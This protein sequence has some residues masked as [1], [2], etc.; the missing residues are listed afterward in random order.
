[1]SPP[2]PWRPMSGPPLLRPLLLCGLMRCLLCHSTFQIHHCAPLASL[3]S[4]CNI[5]LTSPTGSSSGIYCNRRSSYNIKTRSFHQYLSSQTSLSWCSVD[6]KSVSLCKLSESNPVDRP[7]SSEVSWKLLALLT[8]TE[9]LLSI[10]SLLLFLTVLNSPLASSD[11]K[12]LGEV[13]SA[14]GVAA[15]I[16]YCYMCIQREK[17]MKSHFRVN[18]LS[19]PGTPDLKILATYHSYH[20]T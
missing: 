12:I 7:P 18:L 17:Q 9:T 1:M 14:F 11:V 8:S 16:T 10:D 6:S 15:I 2:P 20:L 5:L 19:K 13:V 3:S 4:C